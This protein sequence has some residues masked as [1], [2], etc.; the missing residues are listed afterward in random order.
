M[1]RHDSCGYRLHVLRQ[2]FPDAIMSPATTNNNNN[3]SNSNDGKGGHMRDR[4][5][6]PPSPR[7]IYHGRMGRSPRQPGAVTGGTSG[8][9][10]VQDARSRREHCGRQVEDTAGRIGWQCGVVVAGEGRMNDWSQSVR[11]RKEVRVAI[12]SVHCCCRWR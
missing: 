12:V 6:P 4:E 11:I 8:R 7:D 5:G 2:A 9:A 10:E 3:I 1:E